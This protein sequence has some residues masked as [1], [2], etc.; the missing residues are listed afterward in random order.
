[1]ISH[2]VGVLE[3]V[4]LPGGGAGHAQLLDERFVLTP[5]QELKIN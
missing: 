5:L 4:R 3:P 1:M 2:V